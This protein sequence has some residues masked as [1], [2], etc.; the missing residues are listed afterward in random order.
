MA[1]KP[2]S[3]SA[4]RPLALE[5]QEPEFDP[6]SAKKENPNSPNSNADRG[7]CPCLL[8]SLSSHFL[9]IFPFRHLCAP[10]AY[11]QVLGTLLLS[12]V[13]RPCRTLQ[14]GPWNSR[15]FCVIEMVAQ[16]AGCSVVSLDPQLCGLQCPME[17]RGRGAGGTDGREVGFVC[18][19][20]W[21]VV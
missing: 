2:E 15:S 17:S 5:C 8:L 11:V 12:A 4:Q 16:A 14:P 7:G 3:S 1:E 18:L 6:R 10:P 19:I 21:T 20:L 9:P 13:T